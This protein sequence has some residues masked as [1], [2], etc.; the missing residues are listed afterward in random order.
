[1]VS[2][3][4]SDDLIH[5]FLICMIYSRIMNESETFRLK[6]RFFSSVQEDQYRGKPHWEHLKDE[7]HVLLTVETN[8]NRAEQVLKRACQ[9]IK[10]FLE[11][12][13]SIASSATPAQ[14]KSLGWS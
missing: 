13:V 9:A 1:M 10:K 12:I 3:T 4:I 6:P 14:N 11:V 7:L 2:L 8:Q 5:F